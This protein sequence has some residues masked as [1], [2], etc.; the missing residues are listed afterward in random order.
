[1]SQVPLRELLWGGE[2]SSQVIWKFCNKRQ[3]VWTQKIIVKEKTRY[4]KLRNLALFYLWENARVWPHWNHSFHMHLHSLGPVSCV[5]HILSSSVLT[6][7]SGCSL[8][9]TK[10]GRYSSPSRVP[11]GLRNSHLK[12]KNLWWLWHSCLLIWQEIFH[13]STHIYHT[14]VLY[15]LYISFG[16]NKIR[17]KLYI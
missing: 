12:G 17:I 7:G 14:Y 1:M 5:F 9:A 2:G 3:V 16:F 4:P 10:L 13:F 15:G 6:A 11:L 8:M